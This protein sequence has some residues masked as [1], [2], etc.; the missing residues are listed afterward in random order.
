MIYIIGTD[1]KSVCGFI[2]YGIIIMRFHN[3]YINA[4]LLF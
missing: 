2:T 4:N 3:N 1:D